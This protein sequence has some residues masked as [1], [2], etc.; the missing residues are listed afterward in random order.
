MPDPRYLRR[1][2][3]ELAD[4]D[5]AITLPYGLTHTA[6]VAAINDLYAYLY[7]INRASV[8][9]GYERLDDFMQRAAFS[10]MLSDL[11]ARN[12]ETA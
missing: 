1:P 7:A 3:A 6:V 4:A 11:F 12:I 2:T 9:H 10:G 8:D 5:P